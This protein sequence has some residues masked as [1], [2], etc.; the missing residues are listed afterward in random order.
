MNTIWKALMI[1]LVPSPA[2]WMQGVLEL[3]LEIKFLGPSRELWM[4]ACL[5]I[6]VPNDS[7]VV[8]EKARN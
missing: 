2:I 7:L 6:T 8:I 4:E 3:L 1:N 5:P